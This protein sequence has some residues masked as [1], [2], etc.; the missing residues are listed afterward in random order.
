MTI[1]M[2]QTQWHVHH[3]FNAFASLFSLVC[4]SMASEGEKKHRLSIHHLYLTITYHFPQTTWNSFYAM[5]STEQK[6]A[7]QW[8]Y[9]K[10]RLRLSVFKNHMGHPQW[11]KQI[12][13]EEQLYTFTQSFCTPA[14][15]FEFIIRS[16]LLYLPFSFRRRK[17]MMT[18][19]W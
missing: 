13:I 6:Q 15:A 14:D 1:G 11:I 19:C 17:K 10:I 12:N 16:D 8:L 5:N 2:H 9:L 7:C 4:K 3:V 18:W